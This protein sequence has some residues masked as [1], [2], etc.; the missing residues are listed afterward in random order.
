MSE[1]TLPKNKTISSISRE[2]LVKLQVC[3]LTLRN[4]E[5][6]TTRSW[7]GVWTLVTTQG[8]QFLDVLISRPLHAV[9]YT[10]N[11]FKCCASMSVCA[12][13]GFIASLEEGHT[14][15]QEIKHVAELEIRRSW[16]KLAISLSPDEVIHPSKSVRRDRDTIIIIC[17]ER[18][19]FDNAVAQLHTH[20]GF[21]TY[22]QECHS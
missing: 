15:P 14:S 7:A 19:N 18:Q 4:Q 21:Q 8:Q 20:S 13:Q 3:S 17:R 22:S 10:A 5:H 12:I 2:E 11:T 9:T 6:A 1:P 16:I